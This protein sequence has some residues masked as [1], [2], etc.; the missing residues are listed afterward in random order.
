MQSPN[1]P[2]VE[3]C[4]EILCSRGCRQ[5]RLDIAALQ[6]G[7]DLPETRELSAEQKARLLIELE[8]IMS[9]YGDSCRFD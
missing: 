2:R 3:A 5:V 6:A 1:D 7:K 8:Q 9:V 4:V